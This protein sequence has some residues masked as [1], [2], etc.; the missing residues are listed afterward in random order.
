MKTGREKN[1]LLNRNYHEGVPAI[2]IVDGGW[3][4]QSHKH[5]YNVNSGVGVIFGA[6]TKK[7]L[8][9]GVRN[10][11]CTVCS[12]AQKQS[13]PPQHVCFK[14]WSG[15]LTAMEADI[16]AAGFRQSEAMH[17]IRHI[18][19][20]G[21]GDSSVLHTIHTTVSYGRHVSKLECANH[22]VK[23]YHS[24]LEQL[25]KDFPHFKGCGNLSKSTIIKIVYGAR[26]AIHKRSQDRD[27]EKLR[28]D[29]RAGPR[30]YLGYHELCDSSWCNSVGDGNNWS[31][32]DLPVNMIF[33]LD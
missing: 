12:I 13:S 29:L 28:R 1:K 22:C 7:L 30:H 14:N 15:S 26:C 24:H 20:V 32:D 21:D 31:L 9:I 19:V 3:S 16:I 17:G 27:V 2:T 23:C 33:E 25:V 11:Y 18:K 6:A 4:K 10:K 8:H 5:S